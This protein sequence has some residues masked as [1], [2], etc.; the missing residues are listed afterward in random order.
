[1]SSLTDYFQTIKYLK[2]KQIFFRL[3]F[4]LKKKI[5]KNEQNPQRALTLLIVQPLKKKV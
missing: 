3:Y 2:I 1:M 5:I 4:K